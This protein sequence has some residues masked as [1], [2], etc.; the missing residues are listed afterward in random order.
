MSTYSAGVI[1]AS[2]GIVN[3]LGGMPKLLPPGHALLATR[4]VKS[5]D[6]DF[7]EFLIEGPLLPNATAGQRPSDVRLHFKQVLLSGG[8]TELAGWFEH[9]P[10]QV[11]NLTL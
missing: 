11:W 9:T 4:D 6:G 1:T 10:D 2:L 3:S 7:T 8:K 5:D